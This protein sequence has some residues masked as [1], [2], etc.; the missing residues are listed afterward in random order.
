MALINPKDMARVVGLKPTGF[1]ST[2]IGWVLLRLTRISKINKIYDRVKKYH[3]EIFFQKLLEEFSLQYEVSSEDL[4]RLPKQGPFIVVANHPLGGADGIILLAL[5]TKLRPD[6]KITGNFLLEKIE[7]ISPYIIN[8]NPFED[9]KDIKRNLGAT[10]LSLKHIKE[11]GA[12]GFFPAGEVSNVKKGRYY[13]DKEWHQGVAKIIKKAKVPVVPVYF[14][15]KNSRFFY[16]LSSLSP[17]LQTAKLPSE[18]IKKRKKPIKMR[19]GNPIPAAEFNERNE[20]DEISDYLR[21]KTYLLANAYDAQISPLLTAKGKIKIPKKPKQIAQAQDIEKIKS[22][23]E[24][25]RQK[26][27]VL[28][29][30]KNYEVFFTKAKD[31][32]FILKEIGRL[33]EITFREVG[34]GTNKKNDLDKFDNYYYHMF[35]WD[36]EIEQLAGAYRMGLGAEIFPK[37]G[38]KGFYISTLFK[39]DQELAPMLAKTIEMGRAF[40]IRE[41]QQKP[42]PLFLLWKGIV[43]VTLRYKKH[44]FLIGGV[45]ISNKF[46]NFSKSVMIDF[47]KSN[48][49]DLML[50]QYIRP[51]KDYKVKLQD[52]DK[53]FIFSHTKQ[54]IKKLDKLL[55]EIEPEN[56]HLPVLIKKYLK[57]NAKIVGFNVDPKFNNAIDGLMYIRIDDLP[58]ET[59]K[60]V[61]EEYQQ[62]LL[63]KIK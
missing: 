20:F 35:L 56:L 37:Y 24:T 31:I 43:H 25:L 30:V 38:I 7:P 15:A 41:Y 33:R 55:A 8:V 1:F 44:H 6:F 46:S 17:L 60:P 36:S 53:D 16:F 51:K 23:I 13:V 19:I 62:M 59:V 26:E 49:Y 52:E 10:E 29:S 28:L 47:M 57:Q 48:Y 39:F 14:H 21:K 11:G 34:E 4:N 3:G 32:P 9:R 45:S 40:I 54:D 18:L 63:K 42:M 58:E 5:M 22:E 50:A 61:M 12:M 2:T 27:K